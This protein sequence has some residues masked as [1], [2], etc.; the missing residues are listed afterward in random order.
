[1]HKQLMAWIEYNLYKKI[2]VPELASQTECSERNL[3]TWFNKNTG[4][5]PSEYVLKR[6]LTQA[7]FMLKDTSRPV[8]DISLM[9]GF[10]HQSTFSR[11]FKNFTGNSPREYRLS[12]MRDMNYFCPSKMLNDIPCLVDYITLTERKFKIS[13]KKTVRIDFGMELLLLKINGVLFPQR[14]L[15]DCIMR[16]IF[17]KDNAC[18]IFIYGDT[19]PGVDCD[20]ILN[21]YAGNFTGPDNNSSE[22]DSISLTGGDYIRF[23]FSGTPE[24]LMSYHSWVRGHGLHKYGV[25]LKN[26]SSLTSFH[27]GPEPGT[28][29]SHYCLPCYLVR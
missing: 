3:R 16:F 27:R 15:L 17:S 25:I 11:S 2:T 6:K 12:E 19:L 24:E 21:I 13:R 14:K 7:S 8:T 5:G 18:N 1:M 26:S 4:M 10:E 29:I 28:Y 23:T 22:Y 9:F 20:T